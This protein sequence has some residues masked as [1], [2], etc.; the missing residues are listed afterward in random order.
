MQIVT[1][2]ILLV[3]SKKPIFKVSYKTILSRGQS[4]SCNSDLQLHGAGAERNNFASTQPLRKTDVM[5]VRCRTAF[6]KMI[7]PKV[8][9]KMGEAILP[10]DKTQLVKRGLIQPAGS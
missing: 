4:R 1:I 6:L 9:T 8:K 3:E 10:M 5:Y 2:L 7:Q